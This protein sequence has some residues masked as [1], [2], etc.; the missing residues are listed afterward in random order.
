[1][2]TCRTVG[3]SSSGTVSKPCTTVARPV[4]GSESHD[5]NPGIGMP[6]LTVPSSLRRPRMVSGTSLLVVGTSSIAANLTGWLLYTQR[7]S[8]SPTPICIGVAIAAT[9][10]AIV[11]P[12]P[13][14]AVHPTAQHARGVHRGDEE[15]AD[16]IGSDDHVR[17][18]QRHRVVEDDLE[19]IDLDHG[20]SRRSG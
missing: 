3:R 10:N 18:L 17:R 1:M 9:V 11:K 7:A 14:I 16:E 15:S 8:W 13:V 19:G 5:A 6:P 12:E 20:A 2:L 4:L